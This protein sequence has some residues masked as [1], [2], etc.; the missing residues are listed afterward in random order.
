MWGT[1][2]PLDIMIRSII[3]T[4][5]PMLVTTSVSGPS[6]HR[7]GHHY[8][9]FLKGEQGKIGST[10]VGTCLVGACGL[11]TSLRLSVCLRTS[12]N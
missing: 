6:S 11:S 1:E 4:T 8:G 9:K 10:S 3:L 7:Y 5:F 12:Y 2:V